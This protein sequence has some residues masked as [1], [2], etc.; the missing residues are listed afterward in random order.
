[1]VQGDDPTAIDLAHQP[2]IYAVLRVLG[3]LQLKAADQLRRIGREDFDMDVVEAQSPSH[4]G[5]PAIIPDVVFESALPAV[6]E[7][8]ARD[9]DNVRVF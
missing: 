5:G 7:A 2:C 1:M 4:L 9:E 6:L 8:A 3:A